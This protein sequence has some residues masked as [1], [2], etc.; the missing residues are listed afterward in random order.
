MPVNGNNW[1]PCTGEG[2]RA[3]DP[4][5][6]TRTGF[7]PDCGGIRPVELPSLSTRIVEAAVE[8]G[9]RE[10]GVSGQLEEAPIRTGNYYVMDFHTVKVIG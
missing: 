3:I 4:D 5:P 2:K 10:A 9:R 6:A 8:R 1:Q 7:C